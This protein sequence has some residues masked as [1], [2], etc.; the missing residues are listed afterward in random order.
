[1]PDVLSKY[2]FAT[3]G[4]PALYPWD[5]WFD[6]KIRRLTRGVDFSVSASS[7]QRAAWAAARVR[8]LVLLSCVEDEN[9]IVIQN[10]GKR[11]KK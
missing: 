3:R 11:V 1:M 4:R 10:G 9:T 5:K 8:G 2:E 7:L 6:G